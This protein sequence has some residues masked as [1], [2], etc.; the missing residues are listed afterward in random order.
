MCNQRCTRTNDVVE[1]TITNADDDDE[2]DSK[3]NSST[4]MKYNVQEWLLFVNKNELAKQENE[5]DGE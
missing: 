1:G 2:E 5:G 4:N 3:M